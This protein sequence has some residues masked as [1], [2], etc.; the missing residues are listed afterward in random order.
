MN[1]LICLSQNLGEVGC[2]S[3]KMKIDR[4]LVRFYFIKN[5]SILDQETTKKNAHDTVS[6]NYGEIA[7]VV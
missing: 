5:T 2:E 3:H 7:A 6:V 1:A 4:A